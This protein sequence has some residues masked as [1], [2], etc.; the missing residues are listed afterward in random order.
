MKASPEKPWYTPALVAFLSTDVPEALGISPVAFARDVA[1]LSQRL[2]AEGESFLTKT[3]PALGKAFDLA[4]QGRSPLT[5]TGFK[6]IRNSSARPAFLQALTR[7]VFREDG[8]V[9]DEPCITSI[10]LI[11]QLLQWCKKIEKGF[12][13]ESLQ[14]AI[15]DFISVDRDLPSIG[16]LRPILVTARAIVQAIFRKFR[17]AGALLPKHGPGAVAGGENQ[18]EKRDLRVSYA[19]LERV[20]RPVPYFRSLRDISENYETVTGRPKLQYGL[21][22]TAFVEK[23]SSGPRIIGLEPAE[24][25]WCQQAL[26][27]ALYSHIEAHPLTRGRVNF[28]DQSVNR[29]L[30]ADWQI[31]DTLDMSKASDRNSLELVKYLFEGNPLWRYLL[32]SRTPGTVLPGGETL[33]FKK[34]APMGSAV[35][36][37]VQA[38]VYYSLACAVLHHEGGI[39]LSLARRNVFVYGDDLVVPHGHFQQLE[40]GFESVGLK[41]NQSKC[42]ISGKFRESCGLDA[43]AGENVTPVRMRKVYPTQAA[44]SLFPVVEHANAL[45]AAGYWGAGKAF[46]KCAEAT[47]PQLRGLRLPTTTRPDLPVLAWLDYSSDPTVRTRVRDS[48]PQVFGWVTR[49]VSTRCDPASEER[50]YRESLSLCG[51]VGRLNGQGVKFRTL[52]RKYETKVVRKWITFDVRN[53]YEPCKWLPG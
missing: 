34:F 4:L 17:I 33:W 37:P 52:D 18:V 48:I 22:R 27:R 19:D 51:P 13:D 41:F 20:F 38:I 45:V 35:C 5:T 26:K 2:A 14:H 36:F 32:A 11:R 30:T 21:S 3:L 29:L 10:R 1:T 25:M 28:T 46:R 16:K 50:Y 49:P 43:F 9:L 42:C 47:F 8:W 39:P 23:D 44:S 12:T 24:Y 40:V 53:E 6:R 15:N 31:R 7:R